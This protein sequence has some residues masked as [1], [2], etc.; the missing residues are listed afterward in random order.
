MNFTKQI[1]LPNNVI[2]NYHRIARTDIDEDNMLC[3][4]TV[5]SYASEETRMESRP[6]RMHKVTVT[7]DDGTTTEKTEMETEIP[8]NEVGMLGAKKNVLDITKIVM[9]ITD[10]DLATIYSKVTAAVLACPKFATIAA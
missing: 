3:T 7:N 10:E 9:K 5:A 4:V 1:T 8:V 6:L 2:T